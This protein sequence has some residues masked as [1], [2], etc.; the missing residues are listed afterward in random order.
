MKITVVGS[1][2][3]GLIA[4]ICFA[5]FG[6]DVVC[7][8]TQE[9]KIALLRQGTCP[10][11]EPGAEVLLERVLKLN[12]IHFT[13]DTAQAIKH[14]DVIFVAVGTPEDAAG[15]ADLSG[16]F[17]VAESIA[18][19]AD[20]YV[21]VVD[22][23]TVPVGTAK[24][25]ED[26]IRAGLEKRGCDFTCDV[27]SNPEFMREGKAIQDFLNPNRIV[28]G[29]RTE[30]AF[31]LLKQLYGVF[32]RSFKLLVTTT[33]ETAEMIKYASNAF[34]ATKITFIN[35]IANLCE[36]VGA[37]VQVVANAMGRDERIGSKFLHAGPGY[38]GSCFPKDTKALVEIG[39]THGVD[40]S[41]VGMVVQAN[42]R[43]KSLAI[44][45]VF[46][47]MPAGGTIALLGLSFKPETDDVRESPAIDMIRALL[48]D[49][50]FDLRVYDPQAMTQ[51][52][53]ALQDCGNTD[54]L[55]WCEN[56]HETWRQA[57]AIAI[58]TEWMEFRSID[59][60]DVAPV[61][62]L[63]DFRNIYQRAEVESAGLQ[64]Y[65]TGK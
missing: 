28:V 27:A 61:R 35:E 20:R 9:S 6:N 46:K 63:F 41:I 47:A 53:V 18:Q 55:V 21:L 30:R 59:F 51:A 4:G 36:Q 29:A 45:K 38:G 12:R 2:Y 25:V 16:V 15:A 22:K 42:E 43:Q 19:H 62:V 5:D 17:A 7:L 57:D 8:D 11:Y 44:D 40:M 54:K 1:G 13:N 10:I 33:P 37:D 26:I 23:S 34:L 49:G 24:R 14:G 56:A 48:A 64:Y 58:L 32:E 65:G 52:K 50:R 60:S 31:A 39:K 3:V